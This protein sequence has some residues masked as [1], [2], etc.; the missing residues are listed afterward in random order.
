VLLQP[1]RAPATPPDES[2]L[3]MLEA[4][5]GRIRRHTALAQALAEPAAADHPADD[6]RAT[7]LAVHRYLSIGLP[8]HA[9]DE[10]RSITPRLRAHQ[11]D[12][13]PALDRM[14]AEHVAHA[15]LIATVVELCEGLCRA[16]HDRLTRARL[17]PAA[18]ALT[19]ALAAHLEHEER[20]IFPVV[21]GLTPADQAAIIAELRA[22][23]G[24]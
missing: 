16:P 22:R 2:L 14:G 11:P 7:A 15:P 13:A 4:C 8:Q 5:H 24:T 19:D 12:L 23:R 1:R 17:G 21:A 6:V 3:A 10:D 9:E 20:V 18:R